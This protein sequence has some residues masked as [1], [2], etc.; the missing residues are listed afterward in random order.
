MY[1]YNFSIFVFLLGLIVGSFLNYIIYRISLPNFSFWKNLAKLDRSYCPHCKHQL[2]WYD[3]IPIF[4]YLFLKGKCR[5][6]NKKIS[7]QY[8]LVEISTGLIFLL[9]FNQI[10]LISD[11]KDF[12]HLCFMFY[13][14]CS[15]IVIFVYDFKNYIIPDKIL[16]PA[17]VITFLYQ[18]ILNPKSY[19]LN[20]LLAAFIVSG[21]F[22]IIYLISKGQ[23]M[24][25]GDVKLVVLLGLILGL[26]NIFLGLF[27]A[28]LFG[29]II[30]GG[31]ILFKKKKL[32]SQIQ[33]ATF[34]ITGTFAAMFL[35]NNIIS[36]YLSLFAF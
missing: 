34:L 2:T 15:M 33:F 8:P 21:F 36:W 31:L 22:L 28:F 10:Y 29:A 7:I 19:I 11:W 24:G 5:Y 6:C 26:P 1:N 32:K 12:I 35:G 27:L 30:G 20:S 14:S 17:I 9:I 18:L 23:W 4:S 16:F 3:L 13:V 25:F